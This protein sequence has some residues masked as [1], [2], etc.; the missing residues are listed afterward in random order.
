M[1]RWHFK[2][3]FGWE[4]MR[5]KKWWGWVFSPT[6]LIQNV[7]S[8]KWGENRGEGGGGSSIW[9]YQNAHVHYAHGRCS[10]HLC[11]FCFIFWPLF[12]TVLFIYLFIY[13]LDVV[14]AFFFFLFFVYSCF[15]FYFFV[16]WFFLYFSI[17]FLFFIFYVLIF[18]WLVLFKKKKKKL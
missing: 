8:Q 6:R 10:C 9:A 11:V 1:E 13:L 16:F 7:F 4:G 15:F 12:L 18:L 2:C 3:L 5:E 17:V 14:P